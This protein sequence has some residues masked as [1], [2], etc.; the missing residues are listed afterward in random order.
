M[1]RKVEVLLVDDS[2]GSKA[3]EAITF[4]VDGRLYEIDVSKRNAGALRKAFADYVAHGRQTRR[5]SAA[6]GAGRE[7]AAL[8]RAWAQQNG[9]EISDR[10]RIPE[11]VVEAY[12]TAQG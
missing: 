2:D 5:T 11:T 9:H 10:G 8:I 6:T 4:G 12:N 3:E 7:Q 1:A